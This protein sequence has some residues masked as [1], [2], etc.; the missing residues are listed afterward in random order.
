MVTMGGYRLKPKLE[1]GDI[2]D[3]AGVECSRML[4]T[5]RYAHGKAVPSRS[6]FPPV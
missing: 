2:L 5:I 4:R 6:H 1:A 3:G